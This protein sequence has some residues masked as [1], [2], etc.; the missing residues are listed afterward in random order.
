MRSRSWPSTTSARATPAT[1]TCRS[2][3]PT[4]RMVM[5]D[6]RRR[7]RACPTSAARSSPASSR[8][9]ASSRCC[10]RRNINSYKRYAPGLVRPDRRSRGAATTAPARCRLVGHGAGAAAGEPRARRR[11]QPLPR[12]RRRWSPPGSTASSSG[13]DAA[14]RRSR[15]TPTPTTPSGAATLMA[16]GAA[17]CGSRLRR[18]SG[19]TFG[20]EVQ[21]H[22]SNM[23]PH[24]ARRLRPHR[25]RLGALPR[26]RAALIDP[27]HRATEHVAS[28]T[29]RTHERLDRDRPARRHQPG[30]RAGR[31]LGPVARRSRRP[32]PR[33]P[34]PHAALR[35][36][37]RTSRRATARDCCARFSDVVDEHL[38]ELAQLEVRNAGHTIGNARWEAEQRRA[39]CSPTTRARPSGCFGRQIPV[40]G[41]IDITFHEPLGVVGVI[42]P[43]ELPDA[44]RRLGLRAGARGRQHRG[45]QAGRAHAADRDPPRRARPRGRAARGRLQVR[46]RQGLGRRRALRRPPRRPQGRLHRLAPRSASAIMAGAARGR[47]SAVTLE[48]GGKS[49]N[50][51]LRRRRPREGRG[52]R[53]VRRLRQRRPGL[54]RPRRASSSQRSVYDR[55]MEL[56]EPAVQGRPG[57]RPDRSTPPRWAR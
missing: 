39:T 21:D 16:R 48:L 11:R 5:A 57:R 47:S 44:D 2:A 25:H 54:L 6:A 22:Y 19:E 18:G 1:S 9:R 28:T 51:D 30:H 55:F 24:R 40:A 41:G 8:T 12:R 49:A 10:S 37:A 3:A 17:T 52:H 4:A 35:D 34:A 15:A 26:L 13:L 53:A 31:R 32:T 20:E 50:V 29:V 33:S 14:S 23:A 43:V 46:P 56:L 27:L 38:E 45:A 36:L 42:V 7:A